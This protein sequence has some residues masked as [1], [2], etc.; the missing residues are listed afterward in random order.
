M[1]YVYCVCVG[2]RDRIYD[3]SWSA[4]PHVGMGLDVAVEV[5]HSS[6][7]GTV[8]IRGRVPSQGG[9]GQVVVLY[10]VIIKHIGSD[11]PNIK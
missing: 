3:V 6:F 4:S 10:L 1:C 8:V 2:G 9:R 11:S 5:R 7:L